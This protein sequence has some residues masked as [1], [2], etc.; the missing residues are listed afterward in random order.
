MA[1]SRQAKKRARQADRRTANNHGR[2]SR[3][4]SYVRTLEEAIVAG[5]KDDAQN[6]FKAAMPE[7]HRGITKGVLHKRTVA[8]K[9]SRLSKRIS[10]L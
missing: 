4:R 7:M 9:L 10:A 8:R 2:L 1:N 5:N 6:A 3:I